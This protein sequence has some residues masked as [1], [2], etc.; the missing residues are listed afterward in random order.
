MKK[1]HGKFSPFKEMGQALGIK[2]S[3]AKIEKAKKCPRCGQNMH[4]VEGTNVW[5][6]SNPYIVDAMLKGVPVQVFGDSCP[7]IETA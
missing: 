6:C 7:Q 3:K 5:A 2:P 1:I 4:R